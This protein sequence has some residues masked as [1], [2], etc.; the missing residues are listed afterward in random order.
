MI[1]VGQDHF[2]RCHM[3]SPNAYYDYQSE[4]FGDCECVLNKRYPFDIV[5]VYEY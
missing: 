1:H 3:V 4:N 2:T 5:T